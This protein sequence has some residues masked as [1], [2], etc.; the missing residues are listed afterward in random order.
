[1][2]LKFGDKHFGEVDDEKV[3][4]PTPRRPDPKVVNEIV[5]DALER[6]LRNTY[7][8]HEEKM[9]MVRAMGLD[10]GHFI[11]EKGSRHPRRKGR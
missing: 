6:G 8:T 2:R 1:M 3:K 7:L 5:V 10:D 11:H 9:R 4:K